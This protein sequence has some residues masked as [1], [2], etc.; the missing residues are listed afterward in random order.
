[1]NTQSH[2][3]RSGYRFAATLMA[4]TMALL[5]CGGDSADEPGAGGTAAVEA[6]EAPANT[7]AVAD[8]ASEVEA[9]PAQNAIESVP[10]LEPSVEFEMG[11][12][13][14]M[15]DMAMAPDG[16]QVAIAGGGRFTEVEPFLR[17][18]DTTTGELVADI[19]LDDL[20]EPGQIY[21]TANDRLVGI[22]SI[23]FDNTV[24]TWDVTTFALLDTYVT[25]SIKCLAL[26][27][28]FDPVER[29]LYAYDDF[30]GD[31]TLCRR[32]LDADTLLT[33][34][35][36]GEN[37]LR[38]LTLRPDGSELVGEVYDR[39]ADATMVVSFDPT[40][41]EVLGETPLGIENLL[42]VGNDQHMVRG[43]TGFTLQPSGVEL[44]YPNLDRA[45]FSPDGTIVWVIN[46]RDE[47]E[48]LFDIASGDPIAQ[49]PPEWGGAYHA[50]SADGSVLAI[51]SIGTTMQI[52]RP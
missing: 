4:V 44:L 5:A 19:P 16:S 40:T 10:V 24:M 46:R 28:E 33:A 41:L 47:V 35:P 30:D 14:D 36:I 51:P 25:E 15:R 45:V 37:K 48:M 20:P 11:P 50:W 34:L 9:A 43:D 7:D 27:T 26:A 23:S 6:N 42:G 39:A 32:Q 29:T 22:D 49:F 12:N 31:V 13:G 38:G 8:T 18:Y 3:L 52:F 17:I 21:W 1:M 2:V